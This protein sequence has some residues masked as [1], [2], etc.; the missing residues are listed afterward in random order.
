MG[1]FLRYFKVLAIAGF[2]AGAA[3]A[4]AIP[5]TGNPKAIV[6]W[7]YAELIKSQKT[8]EDAFSVFNE[9]VLGALFS[10]AYIAAYR[11]ADAMAKKKEEPLLDGDPVTNSQDPD[12]SKVTTKIMAQNA[13]AATVA[14]SFMNSGTADQVVYR[15]VKEG[16]AWKIDDIIAGKSDPFS[17]RKLFA[18]Y[19]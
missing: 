4:Q 8:T 15:F 6:D 1:R 9:D 16:E 2:A 17:V 14:A 12:I 19:K 5:T 10:K 3:W 11:K 7:I 18:G 13:G